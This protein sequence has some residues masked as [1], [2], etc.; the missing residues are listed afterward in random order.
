MWTA[1][2]QLMTSFLYLRLCRTYQTCLFVAFWLP[3]S[4]VL[5]GQ[6]HISIFGIDIQIGA[7][8]STYCIREVTVNERFN[9]DMAIVVLDMFCYTLIISQSY[10]D[11][12]CRTFT[13]AQSL[14]ISASYHL[15]S[16][17]V[18]SWIFFSI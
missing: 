5:N 16:S 15:D 7:H 9:V 4:Y 10:M 17:C 11:L 3:D 6:F 8:K 12:F 2:C 1:A 18:S 14:I 13:L